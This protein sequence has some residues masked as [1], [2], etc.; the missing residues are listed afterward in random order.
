MNKPG[1][2]VTEKQPGAALTVSPRPPVAF[3]GEF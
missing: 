1:F 2:E 3:D